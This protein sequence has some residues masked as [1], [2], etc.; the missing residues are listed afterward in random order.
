MRSYLIDN[1]P[2]S[3][4]E[5]GKLY[6]PKEKT[7]LFLIRDDTNPSETRICFTALE[8]AISYV[9][10]LPNGW[11]Y[12][13]YKEAVLADYDYQ[14]YDDDDLPGDVVGFLS[15]ESTDYVCDKT[16]PSQYFD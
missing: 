1:K 2:V 11:C 15:Y 6:S 3:D 8:D 9:D 10:G 5:L 14:V 7:F 16:D 12:Y 4:V 13:I